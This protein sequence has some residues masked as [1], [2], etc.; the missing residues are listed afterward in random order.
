[1][2]GRSVQAL[3]PV[4]GRIVYQNQIRQGPMK[5]GTAAVRA[6]GPVRRED[7]L[8]GRVAV[9]HA[10]HPPLAY[11][12]GRD[13]R[14]PARRAPELRPLRMD[15]GPGYP[16]PVAREPCEPRQVLHA[17]PLDDQVLPDHLK[18]VQLLRI[19]PRA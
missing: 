6:A 5:L 1:M 19:L 14:A 12:I 13:V 4:N 3:C 2:T 16:P 10:L 15:Y 7:D 8:H 11:R 9:R 18:S 17:A